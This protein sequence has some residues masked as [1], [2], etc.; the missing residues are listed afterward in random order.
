[1]CVYVSIERS[2][3]FNIPVFNIRPWDS[4]G[5]NVTTTSVQYVYIVLKVKKAHTRQNSSSDFYVRSR[6][7][8]PLTYSILFCWLFTIKDQSVFQSG[9]QKDRVKTLNQVLPQISS[10]TVA[11]DLCAKCGTPYVCPCFFLSKRLSWQGWL[12][13]K[14]NFSAQ[15][16]IERYETQR[17]FSLICTDG[18]LKHCWQGLVTTALYYFWKREA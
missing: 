12:P 17:M 14:V 8:W 18:S 7:V 15:K 3:Q 11:W 6:Q 2:N 4:L 1:M 9:R 10:S 5:N 16:A 13:L